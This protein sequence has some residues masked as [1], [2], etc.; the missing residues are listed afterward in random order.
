ML[1]KCEINL[2]G[3]HYYTKIII[4][5]FFIGIEAIRVCGGDISQICFDRR[6]AVCIAN[7][8]Y[9]TELVYCGLFTDIILNILFLRCGSIIAVRQTH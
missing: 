8:C 3:K 4:G 7:A 2:D 9:V 1:W 6:R 5:A